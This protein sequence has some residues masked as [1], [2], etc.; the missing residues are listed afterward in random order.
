MLNDGT[1]PTP[2]SI[3]LSF[4]R[5]GLVSVGGGGSAHIHAEVVERRHWLS[6]DEF[7]EA[8]TVARTLPG[9]NV[10]NLA[11]FTGAHLHGWRGAL[12]A[13]SAVVL[14][15]AVIVIGAAIAYVRLEAM[16][17][18]VVQA[19]LHGLTAGAVGVMAALVWQTARTSLRGYAGAAVA[20]AAFSATAIMYFNMAY[21]LV[22]LVPLSAALNR[23]KK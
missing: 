17:S 14:P 20:V 1:E 23:A 6:E 15:G 4:L 16:H 19:L 8:M 10:S 11:A 21:V 9:T 2:L 5:V 13:A 22:V 18:H 7:I 12:C 3:F